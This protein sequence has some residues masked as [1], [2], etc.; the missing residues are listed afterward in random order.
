M[1][2]SK[3]NRTIA[4]VCSPDRQWKFIVPINTGCTSLDSPFDAPYLLDAWW[5][6]VRCN[7]R[8]KDLLWVNITY[9]WKYLTSVCR[10]VLF[11]SLLYWERK[12]MPTQ[13]LKSCIK[14]DFMLTS[15]T[16][17]CAKLAVWLTGSSDA[18]VERCEQR[19]EQV[20][21]GK[22]GLLLHHGESRPGGHTLKLL[23]CQLVFEVQKVEDLHK[24]QNTL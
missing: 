5:S 11:P 8:G 3:T 2:A 23:G 17:L 21:L 7:W 1:I 24:T 19:S 13:L 20:L 9:K 4:T 15:N 10:V 16:W 14:Q 6:N 18:A 22:A 12:I